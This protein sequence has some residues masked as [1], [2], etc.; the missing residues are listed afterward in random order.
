MSTNSLAELDELVRARL[1]PETL[2]DRNL[3]EMSHDTAIDDIRKVATK[4]RME[5]LLSSEFRSYEIMEN[6]I[7]HY[8]SFASNL[9]RLLGEYWERSQQQFGYTSRSS[10]RRVLTNACGEIDVFIR[11]LQ[12]HYA[13]YFD[14]DLFAP[15]CRI[16]NTAA[17]FKRRLE[18]LK[19][20][21]EKEGIDKRIVDFALHPIRAFIKNTPAVTFRELEYLEILL[22]RLEHIRDTPYEDANL[23]MHQTL[24][25]INFNFP[26]YIHYCIRRLHE[27]LDEKGADLKKKLETYNWYIKTQ[28]QVTVEDGL[29]LRANTP[30]AIDQ[31]DNYLRQEISYLETLMK[32]DAGYIDNM[33]IQTKNAKIRLNVS[34]A[35]GAAFLW[36]AIETKLWNVNTN[37]EALE[38]FCDHFSTVGT[39]NIGRKSFR[40][41]FYAIRASAAA[42][43]MD[44]LGDMKDRLRKFF[45]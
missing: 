18:S 13:K 15:Y 2:L 25:S 4:L 19:S 27:K 33:P 3:T 36:S 44:M 24:L 38:L 34:T 17:Q 26:E 40:Q 1:D 20:L 37:E 16:D 41:T 39:E 21:S 7:F 32:M 45:K 43:T 9:C 6:W 23:A 11:F 31:L 29:C 22:A 8:A 12:D 35:Q 30:S 5:M 28:K 10:Y 14:K 42:E